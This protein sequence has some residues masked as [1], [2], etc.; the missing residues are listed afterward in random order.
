[1]TWVRS[2]RLLRRIGWYATFWTPAGMS[3]CSGI[4]R[5]LWRRGRYRQSHDNG[6][7]ST[8]QDLTAGPSVIDCVQLPPSFR[9]TWTMST[10]HVV[11]PYSGLW[12]GYLRDGREFL[13]SSM[14]RSRISH[15]TMVMERIL[16]PYHYSSPGYDSLFPGNLLSRMMGSSRAH[17]VEA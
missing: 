15:P 1:M 11:V 10:R 5:T 14:S 16:D 6:V 8:G 17:A 4:W 12:S 9:N 7:F 13:S 2:C 3:T